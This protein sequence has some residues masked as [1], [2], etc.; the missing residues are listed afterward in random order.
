MEAPCQKGDAATL[1]QEVLEAEAA[2]REAFEARFPAEAFTGIAEALK[3]RPKPENLSRLRGWLLPEFYYLSI[4]VPCKEA[5]REEKIR[6]LKQLREAATILHS[7]ITMF[8]DVWPLNLLGP[9]GPFATDDIIDQFTATLQL[10][11]DTSGVEIEKLAS[12]QSRRGRPPKNEPFRQL[13]PRL[14]R[15]Y[16]RLVKE[17]AS[18]PNWLPDSGIYGSTG[19]FYPFALAVWRCLQDHLPAEALA[20]IPSTEGGLAEELKKHWPKGRAKR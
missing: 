19:S 14:V 11:A 3:I 4:V 7:S 9:D 1:E 13:T 15:K 16:E 2:D 10:L 12:S 18:C 17:P 6:R 5:T 20:A 8:E